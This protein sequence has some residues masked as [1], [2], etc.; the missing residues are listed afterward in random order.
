[1]T[2]KEIVIEINTDADYRP[3]LTGIVLEN[4][5]SVSLNVGPV[6]VGTAELGVMEIID[7]YEEKYLLAHTV[8]A[9][10]HELI[11]DAVSV[12]RFFPVYVCVILK[13]V[14][15]LIKQ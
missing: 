6:T 8:D 9:G 10:R 14:K 7:D 15:V 11:I 4:D 3:G 1:M 2:M 12:Y 13:V 5:R